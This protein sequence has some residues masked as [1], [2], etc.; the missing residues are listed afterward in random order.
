[1]DAQAPRARAFAMPPP[2]HS[3]QQ[4]RSTVKLSAM[5]LPSHS[6]ATRRG[7]PGD[8]PFANLVRAYLGGHAG[9]GLIHHCTRRFNLLDRW[10]LNLPRQKGTLR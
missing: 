2:I 6:M 7:L 1:M 10:S 4:E 9:P 3:Q 8:R 5:P